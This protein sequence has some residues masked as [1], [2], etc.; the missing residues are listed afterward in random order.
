S[1]SAG[2][3]W[4]GLEGE[5]AGLAFVDELEAA[6]GDHGGVVD[7]EG[8]GGEAEVEV[9]LGGPGGE[10][11]AEA[12]VGGDAAAGEG[13]SGGWVGGREGVEVGAAGVWEAEDRC[14]LVEG[15][16]HG[17]VDG[18]AEA[19]EFGPGVHEVEGGV[20]AAD[21]EAEGGERRGQ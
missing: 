8:F 11:A 17:V 4:D 2:G 7:G 3:G 20:A 12:G 13:G 14:G 5:V 1:Q 15:F 21:D 18:R 16:A 6:A 9:V 19:G 10:F